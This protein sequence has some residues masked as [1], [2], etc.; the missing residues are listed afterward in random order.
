MQ[1][2]LDWSLPDAALKEKI[3]TEITDLNSTAPLKDTKLKIQG[4]TKILTQRELMEPFIAKYFAIVEEV[5]TKK[6][7]EFA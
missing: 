3:W 5:V 1:K 6:D 7:R 2:V 4:F